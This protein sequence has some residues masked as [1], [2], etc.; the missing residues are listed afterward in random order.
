MINALPINLTIGL[1]ANAAGIN[2]ETIR[3]YQRRQL[4]PQP[5]R[6]L[7]GVRRYGATD[8]ARICFIKA[9]Q[10]LGFSLDE[11]A[12]LLKL[13]DGTHCGEA[14]ALAEI[15][16]QQVRER[17][18]DLQRIESVLGQLVAR[19]DSARGKLKCPLI[20]SLQVT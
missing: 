10:R 16:L 18:L 3:F 15:K 12:E 5:Q 9:A 1:L 4:M 19:C 17:L 2:V 11:V 13:E 14:R 20:S 8:L 6:P 7:G